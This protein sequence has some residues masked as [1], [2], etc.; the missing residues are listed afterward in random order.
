MAS[1]YWHDGDPINRQ[2]RV[3]RLLVTIIGIVEDV[4]F[5]H[6]TADPVMQ[7]FV[8]ETQNY[9]RSVRDMTLV[10]RTSSDPLEIVPLFRSE[11]RRY[12]ATVVVGQVRTLRYLLEDILVPHRLR[13]LIVGVLAGVALFLALVGI[14]S[15]VNNAVRQQSRSIA[16]RVALGARRIDIACLILGRTVGV[17]TAGLVAG[18]WIS[19]LVQRSLAARFLEIRVDQMICL[20]AAGLLGLGCLIACY[21]PVHSIVSR[22]PARSLRNH[23]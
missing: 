7:V 12:D 23:S 11:I 18:F 15:M 2:I 17:V 1:S 21:L 9:S 13:A 20:G 14:Y 3:G 4:R 6:L 8:P 22:D 10:I 5:R 19:W 16:V